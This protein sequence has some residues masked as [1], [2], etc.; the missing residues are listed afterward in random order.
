MDEKTGGRSYR[1]E[2]GGVSGTVVKGGGLLIGKKGEGSEVVKGTRHRE[3]SHGEVILF[4][5]IDRR[6][7]GRSN[8]FRCASCYPFTPASRLPAATGPRITGH[9]FIVLWHSHRDRPAGSCTS[10]LPPSIRKKK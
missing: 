1:R 3:P 7:P 8:P 6:Q 10:S 2:E 5:D 4:S 9:H